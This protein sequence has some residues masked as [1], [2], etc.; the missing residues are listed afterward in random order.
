MKETMFDVSTPLD[1]GPNRVVLACQTIDEG[2]LGAIVADHLIAICPD[3][4]ACAD[5]AR[6]DVFKHVDLVR[7]MMG[8]REGRAKLRSFS[9]K[10][11]NAT[12]ELREFAIEEMPDLEDFGIVMA[13]V[14]DLRDVLEGVLDDP[15]Q[16]LT[17]VLDMIGDLSNCLEAVGNALDA[18]YNVQSLVLRVVDTP[19]HARGL[20]IGEVVTWAAARG[21]V[22]TD[23]DVDADQLGEWIEL[24][25]QDREGAVSVSRNEEIDTHSAGQITLRMLTTEGLLEQIVT[26]RR[27]LTE[28][29]VARS[30]MELLRA[31]ERELLARP[32]AAQDALGTLPEALE[33]SRQQ[34]DGLLARYKALA[35]DAG[36]VRERLAVREADLKKLSEECVAMEERLSEQ[37]AAI[38]DLSAA[39]R[40][41]EKANQEQVG[42]TAKVQC[43]L[44]HVQQRFS[45]VKRRCERLEGLLAEVLAHVAPTPK[46]ATAQT[47][48]RRAVKGKRAKGGGQLD[49]YG[50]T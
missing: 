3:R 19:L 4:E 17:I 34:V 1:A 48:V 16:R 33:D 23:M 26:Q 35:K 5:L 49:G 7:A 14:V 22:A 2:L 40:T 29:D 12:S 20:G 8:P 28:R 6:V 31:R 32:A 36:V 46:K 41:S 30:E 27:S 44:V 43:D 25:D 47:R 50:E 21:L 37:D 45:D 24:V 38:A 13:S 9:Q 18:G 11:L 42:M 39:L 15:Q 10:W